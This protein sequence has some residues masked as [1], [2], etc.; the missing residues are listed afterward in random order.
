MVEAIYSNRDNNQVSKDLDDIQCMW[1]MWLKFVWNAP[2]FYTSTL[3]VIDWTDIEAPTVD[4]LAYQLWQ[5]K[6]NVSSSPTLR[7]CVL[8]VK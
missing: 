4:R 6:E 3:V 5:F 8:A 2:M 7:S 1:S